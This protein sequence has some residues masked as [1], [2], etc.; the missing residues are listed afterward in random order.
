MPEDILKHRADALARLLADERG[1]ELL[2]QLQKLQ[3][4]MAPAAGPEDDG[5][6][7]A[8]ILGA[9]RVTAGPAPAL[10]RRE[11]LPVEELRRWAEAGEL[12]LTPDATRVALLG[13]S[14]G[15]G[16]LLDPLL[17]PALALE[18][19]LNASGTAFQVLDLAQTGADLPDLTRTLGQLPQVAPEVIVVF[20]GNNWMRSRLT[21]ADLDRLATELRAGGYPAMRRAFMDRI[22][23]G[24]GRLLDHLGAV[25]GACGATV[26]VVV[27]EYNLLGW[28]HDSE[29]ELPP[30]PPADLA[31]WSRERAAAEAALA[32]GDG[33]VAAPAIAAMAALDQGMSPV[34]GVLRARAAAA[35]DRQDL[36]PEALEESRDAVCGL[37]TAHAPRITGGI[38]QALL[39]GAAQRGFRCVDLV[40][41][42]PRTPGPALPDPDFFLDYCHLSSQGIEALAA[43]VTDAVLDRAPGS[44][45]P[46]DTL[47]AADRA[48][49]DLL[50]A[51][52]NSYYGQGDAC[53]TA[54]VD[55]A[56]AGHPE[57]R[58]CAE[59]LL[60]VLRSTGPV[61]SC[62]AVEPLLRHPHAA[63]YLA[64]ML[65]RPAE[66]LGMRTLHAALLA[67][68]GPG[69]SP[70]PVGKRLDL[71]RTVERGFIDGAF[72]PINHRLPERAYFQSFGTRSHFGFLL[73]GECGGQLE[74]TYRVP[75][76]ADPAGRVAV[77]VNGHRLG[78]LA[79]VP[80]WTTA[81][82]SVQHGLLHTGVN[83]LVL[84]WPCG[85]ADWAA[86]RDAD[87]RALSRAG[88]PLVLGAQ[89]ELY[90]L[91]LETG[92]D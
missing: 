26:V 69:T 57:G 85:G 61:W 9:W 40:D 87:A 12:T 42:V 73:A 33:A 7:P 6:E 52:H 80:H 23:A 8:G 3:L 58:T 64:P 70:A 29:L 71:L 48:V 77:G 18:R 82:L 45:K 20:A 62:D 38:R 10:R 41:V 5:R 32:A 15:R 44:T 43:A 86:R 92:S 17:T 13:E 27:P 63:R 35:D 47:S 55:R 11:D 78:E 67:A 66:L 34:T 89:G 31:A 36:V 91:S 2:A 81:S 68:V 72:R 59:A 28:E 65:S 19:Q 88:Q 4:E 14:A 83:T 24:A 30:L 60:R 90:D 37:F 75:A 84:D 1:A 39:T 53:V 49:G 21:A 56:V 51:V 74:L 22:I 16:Y 46:A 25:A 54:L 79:A 50:A 76:A